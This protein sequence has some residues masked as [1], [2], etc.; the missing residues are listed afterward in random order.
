MARDIDRAIGDAPENMGKYLATR[1]DLSRKSTASRELVADY[2]TEGLFSPGMLR[3]KGRPASARGLFRDSFRVADRSGLIRLALYRPSSGLHLID[4]HC[5]EDF[6]DRAADRTLQYRGEAR[7]GRHGHS[8]SGCRYETRANCR[9]QIYSQR[10]G[11]Q[12]ILPA[13]PDGR[14]AGGVRPRSSQYRDNFRN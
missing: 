13:R 2:W 6:F 12:R 11:N 14:G 7:R 4:A 3:D 1:E 10:I 8:L 9:T 5:R